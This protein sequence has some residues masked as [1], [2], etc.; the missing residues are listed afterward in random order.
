[1]SDNIEKLGGRYIVEDT[2]VGGYSVVVKAI[3]EKINRT[4][5][6]KTPNELVL[7][8]EENLNKFIEEAKK[9]AKI[10]HP[11]V[12]EVLHFYEVGELDDKCHIVMEWVNKTLAERISED[13]LNYETKISVIKQVLS[14]IE[15]IHDLGIIH[16]D[17]KPANIFISDDNAKV[18]IGDLGIARNMDEDHTSMATFKYG[19]PEHYRTDVNL[20]LRADIYSAG[21]M[22]YELLAGEKKF[23]EAFYDIYSDD[24]NKKQDTRWLNWHLDKDRSFP[25]LSGLGIDVSEKISNIIDRMTAKD[26]SERY[27]DIKDVLSDIQGI[28]KQTSEV[29]ITPIEL[30]EPKKNNTTLWIGLGA[31]LLLVSVV[32]FLFGPSLFKTKT[33]NSETTVTV[34]QVVNMAQLAKEAKEAA[35][36]AGANEPP[37]DEFLNGNSLFGKAKVAYDQG[38]NEQPLTLFTQAR[39]QYLVSEELAYK[40]T[41]LSK[42]ESINILQMLA[43]DYNFNKE[44]QPYANALKQLSNAKKHYDNEQYKESIV[45]LDNIKSA[46]E[47]AVNTFPR[48]IKIGSTAEKI[49]K[50]LELCKRFDD[51]CMRDW[52]ESEV[53]KEI[54]INPFEIDEHE[55]TRGQFSK[56]VVDTQYKTDAEKNGFSYVWNGEQ[57][58]KEKGIYWKKSNYTSSES[59]PVTHVSF[60]DAKAYCE[61]NGSR[62]PTESEWEYAARGKEG[63]TFPWGDEWDPTKIYWLKDG[64]ATAVLKSVKSYSPSVS[65]SKGY[66]FSGSVWEWVTKDDNPNEGLLKGGSFLERNP[67]NLRISTQRINDLSISNN[68]DG[69]RCLKTVQKWPNSYN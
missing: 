56:F 65:G 52:Y 4:V 25:A 44:K 23:K 27:Q 34:E 14:G 20:D 5:A 46:L 48:A 67:A 58:V 62:L 13:S 53:S 17:L 26:I 15:H 66:D 33:K 49:E 7:S 11:N 18:K 37:I 51:S 39:D 43:R 1:M 19:A 54:S 10:N 57:S 41:Y 68:D 32:G 6:I 28:E 59:Q 21:L 63:N 12:I 47:N 35:I 38:E 61:W 30:D 64:V 9:L 55:V 24:N 45:D 69:F 60:N 50:A 36:T 22:F 8:S 42:F 29:D 16:S 40:R 2:R 31:C 3:D